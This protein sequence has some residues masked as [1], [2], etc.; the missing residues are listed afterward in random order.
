[1]GFDALKLGTA[2]VG[3][4]TLPGVYLMVGEAVGWWVGLWATSFAAV[5]SWPV[6]LSRL[7]LRCPF[8]PLVSTWT[9]YLLLRGLRSGRRND[10]LLLGLL[11]GA[12]FC[13]LHLC[14]AHRLTEGGG[15][16]MMWLHP[17]WPGGRA[18]R[19]GLRT[20]AAG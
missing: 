1:M 9:F 8:A 2:L 4:L 18:W 17:G 13:A 15:H 11:L 20:G 7:G 3:V 16:V 12:G 19:A 5:A 10:Y 6:I 14:A